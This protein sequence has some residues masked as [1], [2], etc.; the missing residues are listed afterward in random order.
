MNAP[1]ARKPDGYAYRYP[2]VVGG[3]VIS[4][5]RMGDREPIES[6]PYWLGAPIPAS[7]TS[8]TPGK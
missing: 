3:T 1:T 5:D 2:S 4:F 8:G 6:I 7:T